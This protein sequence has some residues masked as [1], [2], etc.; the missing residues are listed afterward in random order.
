M[1]MI[2]TPPHSP[3]RTVPCPSSPV[4]PPPQLRSPVS[5]TRL[6]SL[7]NLRLP[8]DPENEL[9]VPVTCKLVER[10]GNK[11][12]R[13]A[14]VAMTGFR[15]RMED[16]HVMHCDN[17]WGFFGVFDGHA[18]AHCSAFCAKQFPEQI[19][20]VGTPL[21]TAKLEEITLLI[22]E[23]FCSQYQ[24]GGST[25]AMVTATR[26]QDPNK[27]HVQVANVGDSR[28]IVA[29][30]NQT[31]FATTDHKPS[32]LRE[33]ARIEKY[34]GTV[35]ADRVDG[36]LAM[37]RAMGDA[38]FKVGRPNP[39]ERKVTAQPDVTNLYCDADDFLIVA[40][41]GIFENGFTDQSVVDFVYSQL[42]VTNDLGK[43]TARLC[44]EALRG[45]SSDNMTAML[46]QFKDGTDYRSERE[47]VPGP[48]CPQNHA[49]FRRAYN[50]MA[51]KAGLSW[52]SA[53]DLRYKH[54]CDE[55]S[56]VLIGPKG[57]LKSGKLADISSD[58]LLA[59]L[60]EVR[61]ERGMALADV[62]STLDKRIKDLL[63]PETY[64]QM[65]EQLSSAVTDLLHKLQES[66]TVQQQ[67]WMQ[68]PNELPFP[69]G[70]YPPMGLFDMYGQCHPQF[71]PPQHF[72][73][74]ERQRG[75][76]PQP[77]HQ[78]QQQGM[79][80]HALPEA[81][82]P[83]QNLPPPPVRSATPQ[84][85]T[86]AKAGT[87]PSAAAAAFPAMGTTPAGTPAVSRSTT[88]APPE[89]SGGAGFTIAPSESAQRAMAAA[90]S[91]TP[92]AKVPP[93]SAGA[94]FTPAPET[95][96]YPSAPPPR[97]H[98]PY[99][100]TPQHQRNPLADSGTYTH[101][102]LNTANTRPMQDIY[103]DAYAAYTQNDAPT[104]HTANQPPPTYTNPHFAGFAPTVSRGHYRTPYEMPRRHYNYD[105][106]D[107]ESTRYPSAPRE[108]APTR[109]QLVYPSSSKRSASA[110]TVQRSTSAPRS[111]P[112]DHMPPHQE[113]SYRNP[114]DAPMFMGGGVGPFGGNM[115]PFG[116][117]MGG[118]GG[119]MGMPGMGMGFGPFF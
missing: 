74:P 95:V 5:P 26:T 47:F 53:L 4:T 103:A 43:I 117:G 82:V 25:A 114:V 119:G 57:Q 11:H 71:C 115:G 94:N 45:G 65:C 86:P 33:R 73:H 101:E 99:P 62:K 77:Q 22:D 75:Q 84:Q 108:Q 92:T 12:F 28:V 70:G 113:Y 109:V 116:P 60:K 55:L 91:Q 32:L 2:E 23:H 17:D 67:P 97:S 40:C 93:S 1:M 110:G 69:F 13:C 48:Y 88:P 118:M 102:M 106:N 46:I 42:K 83:G 80:Q 9:L 50:D 63:T 56:A 85:A 87:L 34:G 37:S 89:R 18:G 8:P 51:Q 24:V 36:R 59:E 76:S 41:D 105:Y 111:H 104:Y 52:E 81:V 35:R 3:L 79:P 39:L 16:A 107:Y 38:E 31:R 30:A 29:C 58:D 49:K 44:D 98:S 10:N 90:R 54:L 72:Q 15:E 96:R 14:A 27:Y 64:E 20:R 100:N 21:S 112:Y 68:Q 6:S 7:P 78:H 61:A 66:N 19:A